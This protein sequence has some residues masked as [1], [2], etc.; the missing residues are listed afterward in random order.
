MIS[1]RKILRNENL[2]FHKKNWKN[3]NE[4][5]RIA[6]ELYPGNKEK[7]RSLREPYPFRAALSKC[8]GDPSQSSSRHPL[9][10]PRWQQWNFHSCVCWDWSLVHRHF[11]RH[12]RLLHPPCLCHQNPCFCQ[13]KPPQWPKAQRWRNPDGSFT[14]TTT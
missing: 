8:T 1:I 13:R 9:L 6:C 7:H 3:H 5:L 2:Y 14:R 12:E 11:P 10:H 4:P